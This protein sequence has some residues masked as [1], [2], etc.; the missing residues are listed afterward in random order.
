MRPRGPGF[1]GASRFD[2]QYFTRN[3]GKD[4]SMMEMMQSW[5]LVTR[6]DGRPRGRVR[7]EWTEEMASAEDAQEVLKPWPGQA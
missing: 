5:S 3:I 1:A 6:N 4:G 7:L 2:N